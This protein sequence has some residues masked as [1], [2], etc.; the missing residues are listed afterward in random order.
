VFGFEVGPGSPCKFVIPGKGCGTYQYR[1]HS[2]CKTFKCLWKIDDNVPERF[3]PNNIKNILIPRKID[4]ISFVDIVEA[5]SP[6]DIDVLDWALRMFREEKIDNIR[7]FFKG[8]IN[9]VTRNPEWVEKLEEYYKRN[10][11]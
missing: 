7:Y 11:S 2:P 3:K 4:G 8:R 5:G 6:I 1:P 10:E 9:Y